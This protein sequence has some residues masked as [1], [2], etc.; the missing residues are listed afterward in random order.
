MSFPCRY[1]WERLK[2]IGDG[3]TW[4]DRDDERSLRSQA[5]KQQR[6]RGIVIQVKVNKRGSLR[7]TYQANGRL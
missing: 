6:R 3:F 4:K 5:C 1:P 2:N 7:V